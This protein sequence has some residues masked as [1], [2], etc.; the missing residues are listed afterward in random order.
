MDPFFLIITIGIK[1]NE[2]AK[3]AFIDSNKSQLVLALFALKANSHMDANCLTIHATM[4][5][6]ADMDPLVLR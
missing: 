6:L 4:I 2:V 5:A 3:N 1:S